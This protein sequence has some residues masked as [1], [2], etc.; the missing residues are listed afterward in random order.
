VITQVVTYNAN[1]QQLANIRVNFVY[2][3][4]GYIT[5]TSSVRNMNVKW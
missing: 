2:N 3:D 1:L 5:V 4:A